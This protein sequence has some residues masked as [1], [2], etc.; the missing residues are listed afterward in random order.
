MSLETPSVTGGMKRCVISGF[1]Q[2]GSWVVEESYDVTSRIIG[3]LLD[4]DEPLGAVN[5][6]VPYRGF[7]R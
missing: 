4:F 6:V 1:D 2:D 7:N 5:G 3:G